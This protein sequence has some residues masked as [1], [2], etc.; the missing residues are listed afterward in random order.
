MKKGVFG[1]STKKGRGDWTICNLYSQID[2]S[3]SRLTI[4]CGVIDSDRKICQLAAVFLKIQGQKPEAFARGRIAFHAVITSEK[5]KGT[6]GSLGLELNK[7]NKK[8][9]SFA[10]FQTC[11]MREGTP[12]SHLSNQKNIP[13]LI[14]FVISDAVQLLKGKEEFL[15]PANSKSFLVKQCEHLISGIIMHD[16]VATELEKMDDYLRIAVEFCKTK[17][18][19][20]DPLPFEKVILLFNTLRQVI[21][22]QLWPDPIFR[23]LPI[24]Q[25]EWLHFLYRQL[26]LSVV[27][28]S[29][30][31]L[32]EGSA[33]AAMA[34]AQSQI[35]KILYQEFLRQKQKEPHARFSAQK[36]IYEMIENM[37]ESRHQLMQKFDDQGITELSDLTSAGNSRIRDKAFGEW[38]QSSKGE[39]LKLAY[40]YM[41]IVAAH[42]LSTEGEKALNSSGQLGLLIK[43]VDALNRMAPIVTW[44]N[45]TVKLSKISNTVFDTTAITECGA[46]LL[47]HPK[48][49]KETRAIPGETVQ[50]FWKNVVCYDGRQPPKIE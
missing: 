38:P 44:K 8:E 14:Q 13:I 26:N 20:K 27:F 29:E 17:I 15:F 36:K 5:Y 1:S 21:S 2:P 31:G 34:D 42:L 40:Q 6:H 48:G 37:P 46:L 18:G 50:A 11:F 10:Y 3:T 7:Q 19:D 9:A 41:E 4:T 23:F 22:F 16:Q 28:E 25:L 12:A 24:H 39:I 43:R 30:T 35:E 45:K 33:V 49:E 32:A 47:M